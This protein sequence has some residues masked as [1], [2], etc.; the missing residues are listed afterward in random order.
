MERL[1]NDA[2]AS[3]GVVGGGGAETSSESQVTGTLP[4]SR[5]LC[6]YAECTDVG[7]PLPRGDAVN[8]GT[9]THA[10]THRASQSACA[11]AC[12]IRPHVNPMRE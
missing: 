6:V 1:D 12:E 3:Y 8:G 5:N 11:R 10:Y 4:A 9:H 7:L 2:S